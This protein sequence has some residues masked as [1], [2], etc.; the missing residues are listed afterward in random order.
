MLRVAHLCVSGL[1][2]RRRLPWLGF[3]YSCVALPILCTADSGAPDMRALLRAQADNTNWILPASS[4]AG[5]R[6]TTLAQIN[7]TNVGL[8]SQSW[9]TNLLDDG[10]Q[11]ASVI[12]WKGTMFVSTPHGGVLALDA[13]TG[14]LRWHSPYKPAYVLLF[15]VNRGVGLAD[16][17]VFIATQDCRIRALDAGTG[18]PVW[19]VQGCL[20]TSNSWYSMAAYV[21]KDQIIVG[22]GGGDN[23]NIGLVSAFS[24]HDGGRL[25]DWRSIPG[26][27]EA[28]HDTWPGDSWKHGGGAVWNGLAID[29]ET[30]TLFVAAGNP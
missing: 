3:L 18:K 10:E 23:G 30:D 11:E 12:V 2:R 22:T 16:G 5:N 27:G 29:Q 6:Y 13:A 24:V 8:L 26:P 4:Y 14:K 19:D 20:D 1:Y 9:R 21:Y 25:W 15:A 7:K 17:K 28:G